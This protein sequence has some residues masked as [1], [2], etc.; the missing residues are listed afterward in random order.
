MGFIFSWFL[1]KKRGNKNENGE[2]GKGGS[3]WR[4]EIV[5]KLFLRDVFIN[6]FL[7]LKLHKC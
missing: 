2:I 4:G 7:Y 1:K 6:I 5:I 3:V